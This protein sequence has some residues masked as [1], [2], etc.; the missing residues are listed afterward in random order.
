MPPNGSRGSDRTWPF[1]KTQPASISPA[2]R[3]ALPSWRVQSDAPRPYGE[4]L[5]SAMAS[6]SSRA[7][8]TAATGPKVSSSNAGIPRRTAT[9]TVGG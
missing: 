5:P 2:S 8:I 9:S 4:S 7:R 1:T 3:S 6:A